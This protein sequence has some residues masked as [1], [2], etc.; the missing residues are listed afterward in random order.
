M[1]NEVNR[2]EFMFVYDVKDANPN[3]DPAEG[4]RPRMDDYTEQNIVSDVRIKRTVRDYVDRVYGDK[5]GLHVFVKEYRKDNGNLKTKEEVL[6]DFGIETKEDAL[7]KFWDLRVFGATLAISKNTITQTGPV[8]LRFGRSLHKVEPELVQGT[9]VMPSGEEK[10]QGTMTEYWK[11]PYSLIATYGVVNNHVARETGLGRKDVGIFWE[12]LWNGTADLNTRSKIGHT[13]RLLIIVEYNDDYHC[14]DLDYL[15]KMYKKDG[16]EITARAD[17]QGIG[18]A[19]RGPNEYYLDLSD[20]FKE[21]E[22]AKNAGKLSKIWVIKHPEL[23]IKGIPN[24]EEVK[25]MTVKYID[26]ANNAPEEMKEFKKEWGIT[27]G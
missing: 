2:M 15:V 20:V 21:L 13:P 25:Q 14:G 18:K 7:R 1:E 3:G 9:T 26:W 22:Y 10:G 16:T 19:I 12:A 17:E 11:V 8:Q 27:E 5:E 4:N 23:E 6:K 24:W